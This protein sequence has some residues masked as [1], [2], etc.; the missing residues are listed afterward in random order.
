MHDR[1]AEE[2]IN[3][4]IALFALV[5][6]AGSKREGRQP[7]AFTSAALHN[8]SYGGTRQAP[9]RLRLRRHGE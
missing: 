6:M 3:D 1:L 8:Q 5:V 7:R 4:V 9:Q 2:I